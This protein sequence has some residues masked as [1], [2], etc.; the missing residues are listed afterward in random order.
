MKSEQCNREIEGPKNQSDAEKTIRLRFF[1]GWR[2]ATRHLLFPYSNPSGPVSLLHLV[3]SGNPISHLTIL[4]YPGHVTSQRRESFASQQWL[5]IYF[6]SLRGFFR[7][8]VYDIEVHFFCR[9]SSF[10]GHTC[11]D[12][13]YWILVEHNLAEGISQTNPVW[14]PR[15]RI[16]IRRIRIRH[17]S[18]TPL[19]REAQRFSQ[20]IQVRK[21]KWVN[22]TVHEIAGPLW[23]WHRDSLS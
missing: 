22:L 9:N 6:L 2:K 14:H 8:S 15:R 19:Q 11:H 3:P 7:S 20:I 21:V 17:P 16:R 1:T 13:L 12:I 23:T 18:F 4:Q 10:E 5:R